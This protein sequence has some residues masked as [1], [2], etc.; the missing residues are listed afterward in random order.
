MLRAGSGADQGERSGYGQGL[1]CFHRD[2]PR[3]T[4]C[5]CGART[6]HLRF[7]TA[8]RFCAL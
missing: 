1:G 6:R 3:L 2:F 8:Y 5:G 4:W 7:G